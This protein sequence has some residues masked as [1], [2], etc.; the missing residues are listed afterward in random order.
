MDIPVGVIPVT[1]VDPQE[2]AVT[3]DWYAEKQVGV[4]SSPLL[5]GLLYKGSDAVY[6]AKKMAGLPVGIQIAGRRWQ[7]EK[8]ISMMKVIDSALGP[9]SFG[10]GSWRTVHGQY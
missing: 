4:N 6:N 2:D 1:R 3:A 7:E 9:R 5:H 10:P 8:V